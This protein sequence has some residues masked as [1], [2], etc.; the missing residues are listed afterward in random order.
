[1]RILFLNAFHGGSHAAFAEGLAQHSRHSVELLS[2]PGLNWRWRMRGAALALARMAGER[3]SRPDLILA[4][5][6]L[7][8]AAFLA[9]TRHWSA[10]LP[11]AIYFHENQ[12][13]Y[14]LPPGRERDLAFAFTNYLS[15]QAADVTIFNSAFH[16]HEFLAALPGLLGRFHDYQ[17]LTGIAVLRERCHV[18]P[19][20]LDLAG[21]DA[22]KPA[23]RADETRAAPLILWNGRWEYD[24][25]PGLFFEAL[26]RLANEGLAFQ[27]AI[28]GQPIDPHDPAFL[29]ARAQLGERLIHF[30]YADRASY[31]RLL[32]QA[33]VVVSTAIQ[34][35][36]GM[37][38]VE[39]IYCGCIPV[40]PQRLNYPDLL[41]PQ[42]HP[43]CLYD[44]DAALVARLHTVLENLPSLRQLP[45][46]AIAAPYDWRRLIGL[47]DR[48]WEE[49]AV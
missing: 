48:L 28:A 41:P 33:D 35:Y 49:L 39:A 19:P 31:A 43:F 10:H 1:M 44:D 40:L 37:G 17:E 24:K 12:L 18:L 21:L 45:L 13:T 16:R 11:T 47:Y 15:A 7:D 32:W 46:R 29:N 25:A 20:G 2:L 23:P 38:L 3:R 34:E 42:L 8:F 27:V 36:F 30:G 26:A 5:D 4:T 6:M 14:P 9:L 22:L